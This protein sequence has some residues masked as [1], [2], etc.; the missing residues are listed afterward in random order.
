[1]LGGSDG[2]LT[3]SNPV[4][5]WLSKQGF[6]TLAV[7]YF[8]S[9][10]L[11]AGLAD[12]ALEDIIAAIRSLRQAI[13]NDERTI[14]IIGR[15]R[16]GE[17]ALQV[18]AVCPDVSAV[19][20]CSASGA[21]WVGFKPGVSHPGAAWTW[22]GMALPYL[23]PNPVLVERA[24]AQPAAAL[25]EAFVDSMADDTRL[26]EATIRVEHIQG[27]ILFLSGEDDR[28]WP[29]QALSD[30]AMHRLV[31]HRHAFPDRHIVYPNAGHALGGAPG[32]HHD[33]V[34]VVHP[35]D[36]R[37][38]LLGGTPGGNASAAADVW[39]RVAEFFRKHLPV[40]A[41]PSRALGVGAVADQ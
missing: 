12:I 10:G 33:G 31:S 20:A 29:S 32:E 17:F 14:G 9:P 6:T 25:T 28:M 3:W 38:Y 40:S 24:Y 2:G 5:R 39:P 34:V 27:P 18:A 8:G 37:Q 35:I 23:T 1:M 36:Q 4:A 16:G 11:P 15:S 22:D 7:A 13:G 30:I 26:R 19:V 41:R 21:R